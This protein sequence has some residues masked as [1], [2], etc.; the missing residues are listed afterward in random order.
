MNKEF[1]DNFPNLK[2][3]EDAYTMSSE[4]YDLKELSEKL[5]SGLICD[6]L[7]YFS[8]RKQSFTSTFQITAPNAVVFGRAFPVQA[9]RVDHMV[10]NA[11]VNQCASIDQVKEGDVYVLATKDEDFD[12]AVW[13]EIM[14]T[15]V[16][17]HGGVGAIINGM[18]RD[19]KFVQ[20]MDFPVLYRGHMPTTSKGRTEITAWN[21]PITIEGITVNPGDL[22]FADVDGVVVIP[23]EVEDQV[24]ERCLHIMANEDITRER[25][26]GGASVEETYMQIGTI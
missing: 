13:G 4:K 22:I 5:Y 11:L 16:R 6:V 18:L 1:S 3:Q 20:K 10:E 7:D 2:K 14:S 15:G 25:I 12:G 8:Y 9:E 17:A 26:A 21:V 23:Q 19:T 24:I